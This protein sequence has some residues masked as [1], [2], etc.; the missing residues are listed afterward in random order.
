MI[1]QHDFTTKEQALRLKAAGLPAESADCMLTLYD[2]AGTDDL[3]TLISEKGEA[4]ENWDYFMDEDMFPCWSLGRLI[5]LCTYLL[6]NIPSHPIF[7][8][9]EHTDNMVEDMVMWF[10]RNKNFPGMDYQMLLPDK[11]QPK[12]EPKRVENCAIRYFGN[13]CPIDNGIEV[14]IY[15]C[16]NCEHYFAT[17][18]KSIICKHVENIDPPTFDEAQ[19][20]KKMEN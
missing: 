17:A 12:P 4:G 18:S 15:N 14:D 5:E 20:E 6:E 8:N 19:G 1:Y 13:P 7:L 10:E 2:E 3:V 16:V 9:Y 11:P